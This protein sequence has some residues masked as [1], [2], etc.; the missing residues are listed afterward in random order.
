MN[1]DRVYKV[2]ISGSYGGM[3]LGD[4]AILQCIITQLRGS[5]PVEITVFSQDPDDQG[6]FLSPAE[7]RKLTS[8][9]QLSLFG[10]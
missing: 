1:T 7:L 9:G 8:R 10:G 6:P 5:L 2:G 4:E 3:N